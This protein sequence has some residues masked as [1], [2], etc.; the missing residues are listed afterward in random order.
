VNKFIDKVKTLR[1]LTH[2]SLFDCKESLQLSK[3]NINKAIY[4]LRIKGKNIK[5]ESKSVNIGDDLLK[6]LVVS[7]NSREKCILLKIVCETDFAAKSLSMYHFSKKVKNFLFTLN[8]IKDGNYGS[9]YDLQL[10]AEDLK[11]IE[12]IMHEYRYI[13]KEKISICQIIFIQKLAVY[14][15]MHHNELSGSAIQTK[16]LSSKKQTIKHLKYLVNDLAMQVVAFPPE[17]L[18]RECLNIDNLYSQRK[19]YYLKH[20][21]TL[22][23]KPLNI[24]EKII[25]SSINKYLESIC[26]MSQKFI[27]CDT[28]IIKKNVIFIEKILQ[29]QIIIKKIYNIKL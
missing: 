7:K 11:Y 24:L 27:K 16:V 5:S 13:L 1:K 28:N 26:F 15:Y 25:S 10:H 3:G 18:K 21:N 4:L 8:Y 12:D 29:T 19:I 17:I 6:G 22:R 14:T 20:K 2:A 9:L 23:D